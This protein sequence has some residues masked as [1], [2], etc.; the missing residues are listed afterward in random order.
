MTVLNTDTNKAKTI[1]LSIQCQRKQV[2]FKEQEKE[3]Q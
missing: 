2:S 1:K 3:N